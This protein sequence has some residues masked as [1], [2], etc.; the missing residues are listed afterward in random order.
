MRAVHFRDNDQAIP[1]IEAALDGGP[2]RG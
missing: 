1:E 2:T